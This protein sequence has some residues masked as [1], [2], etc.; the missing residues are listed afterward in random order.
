M[1]VPFDEKLKDI[2]LKIKDIAY[3]FGL[4]ADY[5]VERGGNDVCSY[6]KWASGHAVLYGIIYVPNMSL[7]GLNQYYYSVT[8]PFTLL[9]VKSAADTTM[10]TYD[11]NYHGTVNTSIRKLDLTNANSCQV[12]T[13]LGTAY[14]GI[15]VGYEIKGTWK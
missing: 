6:E 10:S 2:A 11:V 14:L 5:V 13:D 15:S 4:I 9:T 3:S 7:S 1:L 12:L 8:F